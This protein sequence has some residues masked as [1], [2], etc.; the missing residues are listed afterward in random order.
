[1]GETDIVVIAVVVRILALD[2]HRIVF[3]AVVAISQLHDVVVGQ[4]VDVVVL[5]ADLNG[6][7]VADVVLIATA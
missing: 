7:I 6:V 1:M 2:I 5:T 4:V 3:V